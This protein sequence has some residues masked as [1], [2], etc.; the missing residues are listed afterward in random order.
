MVSGQ[1][2]LDA[3]NINSIRKAITILSEKSNAQK[4]ILSRDL[5]QK[6]D[7]TEQRIAVKFVFALKNHFWDLQFRHP[8]YVLDMKDT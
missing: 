1:Y 5:T 3:K 7:F 8:N 6:C 2:T 4:Q